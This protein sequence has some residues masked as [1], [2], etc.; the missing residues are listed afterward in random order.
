MLKKEKMKIMVMKMIRVF[1]NRPIWS[2]KQQLSNLMSSRSHKLRV[3]SMVEVGV[4][5]TIMKMMMIW[6]E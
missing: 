6:Q 2:L 1:L 5:K 3:N 4:A